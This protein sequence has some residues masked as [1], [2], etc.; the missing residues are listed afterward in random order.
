M[1][2]FPAKDAIGEDN[3]GLRKAY[4]IITGR[5]A[6]ASESLINSLAPCIRV[7]TIGSASTG[8]NVGS[9][10]CKDNQYEWQLQPI[11]FYYYNRNHET[12]PETGLAPD[13]P[14]DESTIGTFY[15][16][17]DVRER[18]LSVALREIA[19]I[20]ARSATD[21]GELLLSPV[22]EGPPRR[23]IEGLK[24]NEQLIIDN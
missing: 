16:L 22:D 6:S 23:K 10:T 5:S 18:L 11:T 3:V 21:Y 20:M 13:I 15:E 2:Y 14:V 24:Y 1:L 19:G 8:K 4:F 17:G 12:V 7:V 9:H